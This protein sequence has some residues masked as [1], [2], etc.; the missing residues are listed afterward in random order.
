MEKVIIDFFINNNLILEN[1][2]IVIAVSTG[3]D[4]MSLL[5]AFLKLKEEY[6]LRLE[7]AHVNHKVRKESDDEESFIR[8]YCID[9]DI[10]FHLMHLPK[11]D[12]ENF[13]SYARNARYTFFDE[14][15]KK[16]SADYLALAHH[17]TDNVETIMM[18]IL[19]GSSLKGYSGI[20][21][22]VNKDN[23][24][25]IR[26][27]LNTKKDELI[28]YAK[29]N[30]ITYFEDKSNEKPI[31]LRNRIRKDIVNAIFKEDEN[32]HIKFKEFSDTL[33]NAS[34]IIEEK[35]L[36]FLKKIEY[37]N[38]CFRFNANDFLNLSIYL[39]EEVLFKL[40]KDY[41][42]S[43]KNI[44]EIIKIIS[45]K[46]KNLKVYY[47]DKL[48][49]VKEYDDIKIFLY[50]VKSPE[51]DIIIDEIK[52][53]YPNDT[54][55]IN[56]SKMDGNFISSNDELWYNSNMLPVRIRSRKPGDKILLEKGYKKVKDLLIDLKI[57]ILEREKILIMEKDSEILAIIGVRKSVKLKKI[58]NNDIL[59]N[60]RERENG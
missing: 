60:V 21:E 50:L 38:N 7:V 58:S 13:Q 32:A 40:L 33:Y 4:S 28:K 42:L 24:L 20:R 57:G 59:I 11:N 12:E 48:T 23:Y 51:I 15:M 6:N 27:F 34:L 39:Q 44:D 25:I 53:Y 2:K 55:E 56:V 54:I 45:S 26:P 35:V 52:T 9:N 19:R 1:K 3:V 49:I 8:K 14:V 16:V 17:A 43:K 30:N 41:E 31:Y 36:D 5:F 47:L 37:N 46:K 10:G 18:R 22:I 29:G